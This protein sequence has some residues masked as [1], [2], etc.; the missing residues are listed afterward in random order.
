MP[1]FRDDPKLGCMVPM[2]KTDDINDQA[3][4]KDKIR[5][6]NVTTE[7]LAE[8]AVSTDKLPDGAIKTSKIADE[9]ITT[10]KLAER[11]ITNPKL[12]DQSVDG[13]VIREASIEDRH[14]ENNAVSTSKIA[15]RSV[16]TEKIAYN[17][18]SRAELTPDVRTYIDKKADSEQVNKSLYDLEKKIGDRFVVEGDVTN[19]PDEEDLTSVKES[20]RDVLKL[21]DRS[22]APEK[23][24]GKGYKILRRNIKSVSIAVTKI[25]VES[26]PSS[27]G[28]LS[29]TINGKETQVA[30][31]VSTDN[32]TALVAQKVASALQESMTEYEVSVDASFII[33]T[34]KSTASVTPSLFSAST[35]G[36]VC[37][38]TDSTKREF[39]NSLTP[40]MINQP[41]TIYEI[42]Y[43][44]D[45]DGN[46]I[47]IPEE[48]VLKFNGGSFSNGSITST[49]AY[50]DTSVNIFKDIEIK[51]GITSCSIDVHSSIYYNSSSRV[52]II[53]LI[54]ICP[55]GGTIV[56]D[57]DCD[58]IIS[59]KCKI[60]KSI[61]ID[62]RNHILYT[63][64]ISN[65]RTLGM[66]DIQNCDSFVLRNLVIDGSINVSFDS[67]NF[68]IVNNKGVYTDDYFIFTKN[69]RYVEID[70]CRFKN[71][72]SENLSD[73]L[74][75]K[76]YC[77]GFIVVVDY[78]NAKFTNNT[79]KSSD[80]VFA[81]EGINF[82][83]KTG[84][85]D[86]FKSDI[87]DEHQAMYAS[88]W[89]TASNHGMDITK[90]QVAEGINNHK[91]NNNVLI[92]GNEIDFWRVST[93]VLV[94]F[95]RAIIRNNKIGT[96]CSPFNTFVYD[97]EISYNTFRNSHRGCFIDL[98]EEKVF[99]FKPKN[100]DIK[101]NKAG[102]GCVSFIST[103]DTQY[104]NVVGN[105][106][107]FSDMDTEKLDYY[108]KEWGNVERD[109]V[110]QIFYFHGD[111]ESL[112]VKDNEFKNY[113]Q[114]CYHVVLI[115]FNEIQRFSANILNNILYSIKGD[116]D[117][118]ASHLRIRGNGNVIIKNNIIKNTSISF[119]ANGKAY[120]RFINETSIKN[121]YDSTRII[122]D[123][124]FID[125][126]D[127]YD[128]EGY[129]ADWQSDRPVTQFIKLKALRITNNTFNRKTYISVYTQTPNMTAGSYEDSAYIVKDNNLNGGS[130]FGWVKLKTNENYPLDYI[131]KN[132]SN[133]SINHPMLNSSY[134]AYSHGLYIQKNKEYRLNL[135]STTVDDV[136]D[137][138]ESKCTGLLCIS[139]ISRTLRLSLGSFIKRNTSLF[140]VA[141]GGVTAS[142][143]DGI[144]YTS[145]DFI[146]DGTCILLKVGEQ[147]KNYISDSTLVYKIKST[148]SI[149]ITSLVG[150]IV[151]TNT[152]QFSKNNVVIYNSVDLGGLE[153]SMPYN[154]TIYLT[155]NSKI[156]NGTIIG[157]NTRLVGNVNFSNV[158]LE[159]TWEKSTEA[160]NTLPQVNNLNIGR[161]IYC[162]ELGKLLVYN[163]TK[164]VNCDGTEIS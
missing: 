27:D 3:I 69:V 93:A 14:I 13:R 60:S 105:Q 97:S 74:D 134:N 136:F 46:E 84:L 20:E 152:N 2:M 115:G 87:Y 81:A 11:A 78:E 34:R 100:V 38:V 104:L 8:G 71:I 7:K 12:G 150:P 63:K 162:K 39:R 117:R 159:G 163:G 61:N 94:F 86:T 103:S 70:K 6:G 79:I 106:V 130:V 23:F 151:L 57:K 96:C 64:N 110:K 124:V 99:G 55:D 29:F 36:V 116:I 118:R 132:Q 73:I 53:N 37:T 21:A 17:S 10:E 129:G 59:K 113:H 41:N 30:V 119:A 140:Y 9:N 32:T 4:T 158:V 164:W 33:L 5:D 112:Q 149:N 153:I 147:T 42:R 142:S 19:L 18:V 62:G 121:V 131:E 89:G 98:T 146:S 141:K 157:N 156:S 126:N 114:F 80:Y 25:R 83:P 160:L 88:A 48:C 144:D 77:S 122:S 68:P 72:Y 22:Y 35:T 143:E 109:K 138:F 26:T 123:N 111:I 43:D 75:P 47:S 154:S 15:P 108:D 52:D 133:C 51:N 137:I 82:Y 44:F 56:L 135:S 65:N 24:I 85:A 91:Y 127:D 139:N 125:E 58:Y 67:D 54:N 155:P 145:S 120:R 40:I 107:D 49:K 95:G 28:T 16:T 45:L 90:E 76:L 101:Y 148:F 102:Y 66:F 31:S 1:T 128:I 161:T 50:I 92:E